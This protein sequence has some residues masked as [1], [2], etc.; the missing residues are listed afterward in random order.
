MDLHS[1]PVGTQRAVRWYPPSYDIRVETVP[2]PQSVSN[3]LSSYEEI[4]LSLESKN[5]TMR[6]SKSKWVNHDHQFQSLVE[7]ESIMMFISWPDCA[8]AIF[9]YTEVMRM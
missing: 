6:L 4:E 1:H 3:S 9:T 8:G 5:Q 7:K 2:I